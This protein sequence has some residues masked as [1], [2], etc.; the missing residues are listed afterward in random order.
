MEEL[1][2]VD[3][4]DYEVGWCEKVECHLGWGKLHRAFSVFI[5]NSKG[6]LLIQRRAEGKMLWPG[7][8]SNS[9]CSHPRRGEDIENAAARRIVEE[10]GVACSL[11]YVYKFKYAASFEDMGSEREVCSVFVG[12]CDDEVAV[13]VDEISEFCWIK[14]DDLLKD[15]SLNS[16]K[17]TPWF[18]KELE[19]LKKMGEI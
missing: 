3:E 19:E 5:F 2:L 17:Y 6:E 14:I 16:G 18:L 10:L 12:R 11:R 13:D 9:C 7:F 4:S 8:W 15:V 1:I